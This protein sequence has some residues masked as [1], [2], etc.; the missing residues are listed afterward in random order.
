MKCTHQTKYINKK[1]MI[2]VVLTS[3]FRECLN[4]R[5]ISSRLFT[6]YLFVPLTVCFSCSCTK[7]R[8]KDKIYKHRWYSIRPY[9]EWFDK[10]SLHWILGEIIAFFKISTVKT[11]PVLMNFRIFFVIEYQ[12]FYFLKHMMILKI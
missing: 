6:F 4:E 7:I 9:D 1:A 11:C 10:D 2:I 3:D 8:K 12:K 5:M